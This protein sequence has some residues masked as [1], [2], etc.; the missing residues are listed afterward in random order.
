MDSGHP[1][2]S[3]LA[4]TLGARYARPIRQS[5]RIVEPTKH[6]H[7]A[8]SPAPPSS[9]GVTKVNSQAVWAQQ[10]SREPG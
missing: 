8:P 3:P 1:W 5:C 4:R 9:G 7:H 2:P 10:A 6:G